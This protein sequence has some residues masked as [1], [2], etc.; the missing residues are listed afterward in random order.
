VT[1]EYTGYRP[2]WFNVDSVSCRNQLML[3][4]HPS[5][6]AG[7]LGSWRCRR[8]DRPIASRSA[9]KLRSSISSSHSGR[10][11]RDIM[12]RG[13]A[14]PSSEADLL[15]SDRAAGGRGYTYSHLYCI[16]QIRPIWGPCPVHCHWE[17]LAVANRFKRTPRWAMKKMPG[18]HIC[19]RAA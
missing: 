19:A 16:D 1:R 9:R 3:S 8:H 14:S 11:L 12:A 10:L 15:D 18:K 17:G 4:N 7:A 2:R 6:D 13:V 5:A